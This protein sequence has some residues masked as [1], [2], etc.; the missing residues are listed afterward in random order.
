[1]HTKTLKQVGLHTRRLLL[2]MLL[3]G[4]IQS[5][6]ARERLP[7]VYYLQ[8]KWL[9]HSKKSLEAGDQRFIDGLNDLKRSADKYLKKGPYSVVL[10]TQTPPSGD[11]HDYM[12]L[13]PYWW[14][15]PNSADGLP[16][17]N[18][19]GQVNPESLN[20]A[21]DQRRKSHMCG[22]VKQLS[23]AYY[24]TEDERYAKHAAHLIRS[25]FINPKTRMNPNMNFAQAIRGRND[26]RSIGIIE[27]AAF[28]YIVD[29]VGLLKPSIHWN[30]RDEAAMKSWF[31]AYLK[32]M[33]T[34]PNGIQESQA[35]N[36]HGTWYDMQVVCFA[37]FTGNRS[38]AIDTLNQV[39]E[40]RMQPQISSDGRQ[41]EELR[42]TRSFHYSIMNLQGFYALARMGD[43]VGVDLWHVEIEGKPALKSA[44]EYIA[45]YADTSKEWPY[46]EI[47]G[48]KP[49]LLLPLVSQAYI[50]Y[51]DK[52]I[53]EVLKHCKKS[54][55][56]NDILQ[57]PLP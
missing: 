37:L 35:P 18:K 20:D 39:E 27:S 53:L 32:W 4:G 28:V 46:K 31:R 23:L 45:P 10:K 33:L 50:T 3:C 51:K 48:V 16:Y 2:G 13:G 9:D 24:F 11:K 52:Q 8:L 40:R 1:M 54:D 41:E 14:P 12:S 30:A 7:Q 21:S 47:K 15:D 17:I 49:E 22:A 36:N 25:W 57:Y 38:I 19:D 34:H 26:G 56:S 29:A 5:A 43:R 55:L 44:L 42:R 6:A